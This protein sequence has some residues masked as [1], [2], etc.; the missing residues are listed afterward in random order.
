MDPIYL[1]N[2]WL[3][4][5]LTLDSRID[6]IA[7]YRKHIATC[8]NLCSLLSHRNL[9]DEVHACTCLE[10]GIELDGHKLPRLFRL[11]ERLCYHQ[12]GPSVTDED[13][14]LLDN[15]LGAFIRA[16][17]QDAIGYLMQSSMACVQQVPA[18]HLLVLQRKTACMKD[19]TRRVPKPIVV[20]AYINVGSQVL[21]AVCGTTGNCWGAQVKRAPASRCSPLLSAPRLRVETRRIP[22]PPYIP[23]NHLCTRL[24]V[25]APSLGSNSQQ[26]PV[27]ALADSD[28]LG[29][30]ML[31]ALVDQLHVSKIELEKPLLVQLAV[32]G[33]RTKVN[34]CCKINFQ[35][36]PIV[37]EYYFDIVNVDGYDLILG[38]PLLFQHQVSL[39]FK[40]TCTVIGSNTTL[41]INSTEV[42]ILSS[43]AMDLSELALD[44]VRAELTWYAQP[45]CKV[46]DTTL[47][48]LQKT[49]HRYPIIDLAKRYHFRPSQCPEA[50]C[51]LWNTKSNQY[52][53]SEC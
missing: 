39:T 33:S 14:V 48:P 32:W 11:P 46:S 51:E 6:L 18:G 40:D 41:P 12:D 2:I 13:M 27:R 31:S 43:R 4:L 35:Y 42:A 8:C 15:W 25:M 36:T 3:P 52:I 23:C 47:P 50:F 10:I 21:T 28:S 26:Q 45:L 30:F 17:Q 19:F 16:L 24:S 20:V 7:W 34:T 29:D 44:Q 49:N 5:L 22:R 9:Q 37:E 38:T 1:V 53:G